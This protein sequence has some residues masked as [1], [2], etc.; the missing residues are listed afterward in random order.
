MK[1]VLHERRFKGDIERLRSPQRVAL[2]EVERV[3]DL[4]L[5]GIRADSVLDVGTGSGI[6]AESFI[7]RVKSVTGIDPNLEM[8]KAAKTFVPG[9]IFLSGTVENIPLEDKSFDI[10]F[11]GHVLHES[12]DITKALSEAR[13]VAKQRV[14]ILEWP[15]KE[16]ENGPPLEHRLKSKA[17]LDAAKKAGFAS[18][19]TTQLQQMVLHRLTV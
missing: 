16:E 19:E 10:V 18:S 12:D 8:L 13:R 11:M 2:L 14:C 5:E 3:V 7:H 6:F 1:E 15:Y 9:G 4:C 17:I